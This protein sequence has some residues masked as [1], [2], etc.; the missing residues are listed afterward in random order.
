MFYTIH[1]SNS[2]ITERVYRVSHRDF[3]IYIYIYVLTGKS[4]NHGWT[5]GVHSYFVDELVQVK[6]S[7]LF[8]R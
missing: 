3:L 2:F 7:V 1:V 6:Y 4:G 8:Q 5:P